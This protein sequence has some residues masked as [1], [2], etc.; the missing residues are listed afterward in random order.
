[1]S[2]TTGY[3]YAVNFARGYPVYSPGEFTNADMLANHEIDALLVISADLGAHQ[4][5]KSVEW[6]AKIP[7]ISIDIAPCPTTM[8]SDVVLPGVIAGM[9]CEGTFYRMD[10][11]PLSVNKFTDPPFDFTKSDAD[12]LKQLNDKIREIKDKNSRIN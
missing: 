2:Y 3:P 1:M 8:L 10:H 7:V 11:V 9:E 4:P 12:T 6:M 5:R